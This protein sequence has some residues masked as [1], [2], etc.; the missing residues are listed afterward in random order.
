VPLTSIRRESDLLLNRLARDLPASVLQPSFELN[1]GAREEDLL[2][3]W[4]GAQAADGARP[5]LAVGPGTKMPAKQWPIERFREVVARLIEEFDVW[6]VVFGGGE[7]RQA[8]E[9]LLNDWQRG[10]NAAGALDIRTAALALKRCAAY[11]GNDTGTMHLAAAV[12]VPSVAI[13]S[14]RE[15]PGMWYPHGEE[16]AIFRSSIDCEGCGLVRCV[17][18]DNECLKRITVDEVTTAAEKLLMKHTKL[19]LT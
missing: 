12:G 19:C 9:I 17:V 2:N 18:R 13:F 3:G 16:N 4:L 15:R 1:L 8:G 10:Y 7:D 5:W 14:S 11:V 6:P